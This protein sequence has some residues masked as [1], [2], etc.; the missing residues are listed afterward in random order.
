MFIERLQDLSI[1]HWLQDD[2]LSTYTMVKV[3]DGFPQEDLQ[4]PS[5]SIDSHDIRP[6]Q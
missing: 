5:V 3:N 4:I 1:F 2:I 6:R